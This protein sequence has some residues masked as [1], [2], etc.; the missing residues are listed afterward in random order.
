MWLLV[1]AI[2]CGGFQQIGYSI[3]YGQGLIEVGTWIGRTNAE[4]YGLPIPEDRII[5]APRSTDQQ[6]P[7]LWE[8][9]TRG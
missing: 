1:T 2:L 4:Y 8:R 3:G 7:A 5:E 6:A 9:L